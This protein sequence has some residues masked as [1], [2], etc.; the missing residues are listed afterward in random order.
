MKR[1]D[2]CFG[3][4]KVT[5]KGI[6]FHENYYSAPEVISGKW[7]EVAGWTGGW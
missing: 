2:Y 5:A 6:C 1:D 3:I 7:F 4:A